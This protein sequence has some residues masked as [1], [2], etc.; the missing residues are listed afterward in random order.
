MGNHNNKIK[1]LSF[2]DGEFTIDTIIY[3]GKTNQV[4]DGVSRTFTTLGYTYDSQEVLNTFFTCEGDRIPITYTFD[5]TL[6]YMFDENLI[7]NKFMIDEFMECRI[8]NEDQAKDTSNFK[9]FNK[10]EVSD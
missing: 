9:E 6:D 3:K 8:V 1:S 10:F 4:I 7:I 5:H 2:E